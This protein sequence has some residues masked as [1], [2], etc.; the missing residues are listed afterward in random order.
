MTALYFAYGSNLDALQMRQRCPGS[1]LMGAGAL[2]N[3]AIGF[4]GFSARWNGAVATI[5]QKRGARTEGLLYRVTPE[6]LIRLDG[7]EG[8]PHSYRR[9]KKIVHT[10]DGRRVV[11][12]VY[13]QPTRE[14]EAP[15]KR[16]LQVI[17]RAYQ[18]HAFDIEALVQAVRA[19]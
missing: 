18:Q 2:P 10:D 7:F 3:H 19:A 11:A 16:Y 17:L 14:P 9:S 4:G 15:S 6:D 1:A 13:V 8:H 5:A 12:H